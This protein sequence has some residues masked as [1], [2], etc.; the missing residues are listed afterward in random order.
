MKNTKTIISL[1]IVAILF[2][3]LCA[4]CCKNGEDSTEFLTNVFRGEEFVLQE[5]WSLSTIVTPSYDPET[6]TVRC[7]AN[8]PVERV[9]ADGTVFYPLEYARFSLTLDEVVEQ[10][11]A[12]SVLCG[13]YADDG[14]WALA[15]DYPDRTRHILLTHEGQAAAD[16][17]ASLGNGAGNVRSIRR[18]GDRFLILTEETVFCFETDGTLRFTVNGTGELVSLLRDGN[19]TLWAEGFYREGRGIAVVNLEDR[20]FGVVRLLPSDVTELCE[21]AD[22]CL[23]AHMQDGIYLL[24]LTGNGKISTEK[25]VDFLAS[26]IDGPNAVLL[27]AVDGDTFLLRETRENETHDAVPVLYRRS[28]DIDLAEITTLE[29]AH[30]FPLDASLRSFIVAFNKSETG[31]R[32]VV[33]DYSDRNT[34]ENPLAGAEQLAFDIVTGGARPDVVIGMPGAEDVNTLCRKGLFSD[35]LQFMENDD[36]ITEDN[37]FGAVRTAYVKDGK[38]WG[39]PLS[40]TVSSI[41]SVP[42]LLGPYADRKG[43]SLDDLLDFAENLPDGTRLINGL[44]RERAADL[45]LGPLGYR[46]FLDWEQGTCSFDSP[47]FLRWLN[48][49]AALP[50]ARDAE[51]ITDNEE[52]HRLYRSREIALEEDYVYDLIN[53]Y[54]REAI[55]GTDEPV[56]IGYPSENGDGAATA[57]ES[58]FLIT[59]YCSSPDAAW[60]FIRF[61]FRENENRSAKDIKEIPALKSTFDKVALVNAEK[62]VVVSFNGTVGVFVPDPDTPVSEDELDTPGILRTINADSIARLKAELDWPG[63]PIGDAL[64]GEIGEIVDEEISVFLAS[65]ISAKDCS[66]RIQSRV[67]IWLAEHK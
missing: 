25:K 10:E 47:A 45:L 43:W 67:S 49:L 31:C 19:G 57:A 20:S 17:T 26:S 32:I 1:L 29:L 23:Y 6:N 62:S 38:L 48:F 65:A 18:D 35:L 58:M 14:F 54:R 64:P 36:F 61:C 63:F 28:T 15:E 50:N 39:L 24:K 22:G 37:L 66:A 9:M 59:S 13:C 27:A 33:S 60:E 3:S 42:E 16:L 56:R 12:E 5:G 52:L 46:I 7:F 21:G 4:V 2:L 51:K 8:H 41:W 40:F 34:S 55:W 11:V 53:W 30:A 44:S